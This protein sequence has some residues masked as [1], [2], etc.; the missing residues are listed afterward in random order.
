MKKFLI[1]LAVATSAAVLFSSCGK[2]CRC[3]YKKDGE[4]I[5]VRESNTTYFNDID[6]KEN[7]LSNSFR[8]TE[9]GVLIEYDCK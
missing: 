4:K 5:F 3:T 6:Y 2:T 1:L 9:D 8:D 7:C